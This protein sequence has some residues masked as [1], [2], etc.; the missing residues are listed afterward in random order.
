MRTLAEALFIEYILR[1]DVLPTLTDVDMAEDPDGRYIKRAHGYSKIGENYE[2]PHHEKR[3]RLANT[4]T[5]R[6]AKKAVE[7]A[8]VFDAASRAIGSAVAAFIEPRIGDLECKSG[9]IAN[10]G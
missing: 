1:G 6:L 5:F 9:A 8:R 10:G 7:D 4:M 3:Y 2:P